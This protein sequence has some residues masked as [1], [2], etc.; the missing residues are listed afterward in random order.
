MRTTKAACILIVVIIAAA[1]PAL[2]EEPQRQLGAH[3]HGHGRLNIGIEGKKLSMEL[4]VPGA[5]IVGFEHEPS[6]AEQR[7]A[8]AEAKARLANASMLF[9]PEPKAGCT[10]EQAKVSVEAGHEHEHHDHGDKSSAA[11]QEKEEAGHSEFHGEYSFVCTSPSRLASMTFD[12]FK[13]F[14]NAQ[15]LDITIVS[16]KGQSRFEVKRDN[17]SL[18]LTGIM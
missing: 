15:E 16:P 14:P 3:V 12:Y 10:L 4:E 18:D 2:A 13:E 8:L 7:A 5:D 11:S 6:T 1:F 17:P 9:A